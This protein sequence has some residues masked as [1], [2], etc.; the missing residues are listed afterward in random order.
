[1]PQELPQDSKMNTTIKGG[2]TVSDARETADVSGTM[3]ISPDVTE[4]A[5]FYD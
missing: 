1:M 2:P 5:Y 3:M 4:N